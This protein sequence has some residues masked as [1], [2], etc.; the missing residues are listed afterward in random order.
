MPYSFLQRISKKSSLNNMH[1][2]FTL[3]EILIVVV[4]IAI[5]SGVV[6]AVI[7]PARY[8][9]RANDAKR[10]RDIEIISQALS[11]SYADNNVYP[12]TAN[13][14]V[15]PS[16]LA[17]GAYLGAIPTDPTATLAYCYKLGS[18]SQNYDLCACMEVMP[19]QLN[20]AT[21]CVSG[22]TSGNSYCVRA[23]F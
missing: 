16:D 8:S 13:T 23:P 11:Q 15:K 20:G 2:A 10:I 21:S 7:N 19:D 12:G 3:I 14:V 1:S 18:T 17:L 22:C 4:I 6:I 9:A 5:L